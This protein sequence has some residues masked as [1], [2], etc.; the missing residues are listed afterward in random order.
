MTLSVPA[1]FGN[2]AIPEATYY[3]ERWVQASTPG[4]IV[5]G[6]STYHTVATVTMPWPG[7]L[8]ASLYHSGWMGAGLCTLVCMS[9]GTAPT[10]SY[11]G[12]FT[13]YCRI[14]AWNTCGMFAQWADLG[15][16]A[17]VSIGLQ[18]LCTGGNVVW[19]SS[20]TAGT[21]RLQRN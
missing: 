11:G 1:P 9:Y 16:G 7:A 14:D 2:F 3:D 18:V 21:L 10:T 15:A 19:H 5:N 12:A 4:D 13:E 20:S 8:T 6:Q 17:V